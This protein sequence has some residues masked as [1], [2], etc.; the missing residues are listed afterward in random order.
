MTISLQKLIAGLAS[1][2]MA[3]LLAWPVTFAYAETD[4][5]DDS[6]SELQR[7]VEESGRAYDEATR[8]VKELQR[9][10]ADNGSRIEGLN[11][12]IEEQQATCEVSLRE[13][14]KFHR[15]DMNLINMVFSSGSIASFFSTMD[16]FNRVQEKYNTDLEQLNAMHSERA[17][18][19]EALEQARSEAE[20]I[21]QQAEAAFAD[22]RRKR[23]EA[24]A[25]AR[26]LAIEDARA[27]QDMAF[28]EA[29]TTP[30]GADW[31]MDRATFINA[32]KGRLNAYLAGSPLAGYGANFAAA[33]WE[34]GI[35]PRFSA[36]ISCME[37]SKGRYCFL[38]HNAWG[39]GQVSWGSWD[40]AISAHARGLARGYGYTL[41]L[42]GAKKYC[43]PNWK[44]WYKTVGSE[45]ARI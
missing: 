19:Q 14:Y 39:W 41:S 45:M 11:D 37:S 29:A 3:F 24:Q 36:A 9:Q 15:D 38:P 10:I 40:E 16:Y 4:A 7:Q 23:D 17:Q 12:Q 30:D 32:W 13:L 2:L 28:G 42:A 31:S 5:I 8:R 25:T 26:A 21:R 22:A 34:N 18:A 33:S 27:L 43:P 44:H 6:P 1:G 35:D 20:G